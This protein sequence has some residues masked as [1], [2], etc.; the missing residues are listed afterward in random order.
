MDAGPN[1]PVRASHAGGAAATAALA[2]LPGATWLRAVG[3]LK[4]AVAL[5]A[6]YAVALVVATGI[7]HHNGTEAAR[8]AVYH[9][10]W[11]IGL[12]GLLAA[13]IVAAALV[14][15]PWK[16]R[17]AGFLAAHLGVLV[18]L[19]GCWLS[20]LRG[21]TAEMPLFEGQ[22]AYRVADAAYDG[23]Y[24]FELGFRV[25]LRECRR[26]LDPGSAMPSH[27]SSLVDFLDLGDPPKTLRENVLI[28]LNSPAE[29]T[30]PLSGRNY[31]LFQSDCQGPL[32]PGNEGF[33]DLVGSDRSRDHLYYSRLSV[34]YDPGRWLKY[35]G[36][37]LIVLGMVIVY[38]RR[39]LRGTT[40]HGIDIIKRNSRGLT[41][42]GCLVLAMLFFPATARGSD[43]ALDWTAW[44]HLP[45][46]AEGRVAPLDTLARQTVEVICGQA[47]PTL[48][49]GN[50]QPRCYAAAELFFSWLAEPE[51]W[52]SVRFL[53][54]ANPTL[55][56]DVLG[57]PL[58]DAEDRRLRFVSPAELDTI[59]SEETLT[60]LAKLPSGTRAAVGKDLKR[61]ADAYAK[62]RSLTFDIPP[63][64]ELS[65]RLYDR[66][67]LARTAWRNLSSAPR[68]ARS[69]SKNT[70]V[71]RLVV[72]SDRLLRDLLIA[73]HSDKPDRH[74]IESI[75]AGLH[76]AGAVLAAAL[77]T[78]DDRA[79]AALAA[80]LGRQTAELHM[81]I[82]DAGD[83]LRLAPALGAAALEEARPLDEDA[84]PWL[85]FQAMLYGPN[86]LLEA[87][88][89][90]ELGAV[91]QAWHDA[92]AVYV[93]RSANDRPA[94]FAAAMDRLASALRNLGVK[95]TPLRAQLPLLH[96]DRSA[97]AATAYPPPDSTD[98]EVFY[99]RL[100]PFYWASLIAAAATLCLLLTVGRWRGFALAAGVALLAISQCFTIA[101]LSVRA[102]ITHLAPLTGMFESVVVVALFV[103]LLGLWLTLRPLPKMEAVFQRR[104]FLL[105]GSIISATALLLAYCAPAS[106]MHRDIGAA[107]PILRDN[108]WLVV[109]VT[110]IM[111]SYAAAG[112]AWL[113]GNAALGYYL[114][115]RYGAR[116][117]HAPREASETLVAVVCPPA[118]C[119]QLAGFIDTAIQV[120]VVLLTAGIILGA[121]WAD[122]AW[123]RFWGWDPKETWALISLLVYM[124]FLHAQRVG[125]SADFGVCVT[126]VLGFSVVLFT[127][128][129]VNF[130]MPGGK[131]SYGGAG[132][133]SWPMC[134]VAVAQACFL[135]AAAMRRFIE[136]R[137]GAKAAAGACAVDSPSGGQTF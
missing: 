2:R 120:T 8:D 28:T 77:A 27:Y 137:K 30:D 124:A 19:A 50:E 11:F 45:A 48:A 1:S 107:T 51:R 94:R 10:A 105:A 32:M 26:T 117:P 59:G 99:N 111:M 87:Y 5:I 49:V 13:N 60:R 62:F 76:R 112:M 135:A 93:D 83:A 95:T 106:V 100:D 35:A 7:E 101:G 116:T 24:W 23:T 22:A 86:D 102:Y 21:V 113:L 131:H 123:G 134:V 85:S 31:R 104:P 6:A 109:H 114:F 125:W 3:S 53:A 20:W 33:D 61:L 108:F 14:R 25:R 55:R 97:I 46:M 90:T 15:L 40:L 122:N 89:Q 43:T 133:G 63:A 103:A 38:A 29:F 82:F 36:S 70:A 84:S 115:G 39:W 136:S 69:I 64:G 66:L 81:A 16:W 67:R 130:L 42:P 129:G 18:L 34:N 80:E 74:K 73:A 56:Q 72:E 57:L 92:R 41:A 17:Q 58:T 75:A 71:R 52:E 54:A 44:R 127:W 91:R 78:S 110:T 126:A 132:G 12:H 47:E 118:A 37:L 121:L 9:A 128:Y 79:L 88:P 68:A 96:A 119:R 65:P 98:A 4:L